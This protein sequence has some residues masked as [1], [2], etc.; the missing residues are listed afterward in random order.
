MKTLNMNVFKDSILVYLMIC[1]G[2]DYLKRPEEGC[3]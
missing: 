2:I 3:N 1:D